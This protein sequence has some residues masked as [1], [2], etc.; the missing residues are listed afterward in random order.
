MNGKNNQIQNTNQDNTS[1]QVETSPQE[2]LSTL[3]SKRKPYNISPSEHQPKSK[4]VKLSTTPKPT[5]DDNNSTSSDD[6]NRLVI[7]EYRQP[8][9]DLNS[10]NITDT[11]NVTTDLGLDD[12]ASSD[13]DTETHLDEEIIEPTIID[14]YTLK[15]PSIKDVLDETE[16]EQ[17]NKDER[18]TKKGK[19]AHVVLHSPLGS[20]NQTKEKERQHSTKEI[21]KTLHGRYEI[22]EGNV[23]SFS[24]LD[25]LQVTAKH[26]KQKDIEAFYKTA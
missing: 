10:T 25:L 22:S 19:Y 7:E 17:Q 15:L 8:T 1:S 20:G 3:T 2:E 14:T 6:S 16:T 18:I 9:D 5:P 13:N 26:I 21:Q 12:V 4:M 11:T 24:S 23:D